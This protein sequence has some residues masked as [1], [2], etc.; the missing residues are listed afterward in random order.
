MTRANIV[1]ALLWGLLV[2]VSV[3]NCKH[4]SDPEAEDFDLNLSTS[5]TG[6]GFISNSAGPGACPILCELTFDD[7]DEVTLTAEAS[8]GSVFAGWSGDCDGNNPSVTL[9]VDKD[10]ACDAQ[11]DLEGPQVLLTISIETL[12]GSSG[13]VT[14]AGIDCGQGATDCTESYPTNTSVHLEATFP[15][16]SVFKGWKL[17]CLSFTSAAQIDLLMNS[18]KTCQAS[19]DWADN[20][21]LQPKGSFGFGYRTEAGVLL[22]SKLIV[23]GFDNPSGQII[24][25]SNLDMLTSPAGPEFNS[26]SGARGLSSF[27]STRAQYNADVV[28]ATCTDARQSSTTL[29]GGGFTEIQFNNFA[30]GKSAHYKLNWVGIADFE[31]GRY[32]LTDQSDT[33]QPTRQINLS[34]AERSCPFSQTIVGDTAFVVGREGV[35]GTSTENCNNWVG[36][37]KVDLDGDSVLSF[38]K[39]GTKLRDV[40]YGADQ[41]LYVSDFEEDKVYVL[42]SSS[43]AVQRSFSVGDGPVGLKLN[44][45]AT[46]LWVTN[47]NSNKLQYWNLTNDTLIDEEDSGGVHPVDVFI[48]GANGF[49]LNYGDAA[50][51]IG[52]SLRAFQY[53]F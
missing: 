32:R 29:A 22:G 40:A 53:S 45:M 7:G 20:G 21:G 18:D 4:S 6:I 8:A 16:T 47:W 14:G 10:L 38:T 5:G 50:G 23:A 37:W 11:F 15:N 13:K 24:D 52:G 31:F 49:V 26:C 30:P 41:R 43:M 27:F 9:T 39:F 46:G 25:I 2:I 19:F 34:G 1:R 48:S 28:F 35:A 36:V 33:P 3:V 42:N 12:S 44:P 51:N 17:D